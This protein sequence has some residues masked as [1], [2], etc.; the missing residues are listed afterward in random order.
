MT[1]LYCNLPFL[2]EIEKSSKDLR[3]PLSDDPGRR[4]W[5]KSH[6]VRRSCEKRYWVFAKVAGQYP[7]LTS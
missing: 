1:F 4:F 6:L 7:S 2:F 5:S 3:K